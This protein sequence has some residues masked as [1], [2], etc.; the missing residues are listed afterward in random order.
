M[1]E[2]NE[3]QF[4]FFQADDGTVHVNVLLEKETVW[5]TQAAM[6]E[7]FACSSD[8]ISLHLKNIYETGELKPE[9]TTEDFSVVRKEGNRQVTRLI[10]HHNL[11]AIIAVNQRKATRPVPA[12]TKRRRTACQFGRVGKRHRQDS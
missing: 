3:S 12:A 10:K 8:N 2:N 11:D 4:L 5:L 1:N 6:A 7:L 9:A